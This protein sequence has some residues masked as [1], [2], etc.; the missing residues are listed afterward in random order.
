[1]PE[2]RRP[3]RVGVQLLRLGRALRGR[4]SCVRFRRRRHRTFRLQQVAEVVTGKSSV[5]DSGSCRIID[6]AHWRAALFSALTLTS[7]SILS[8]EEARTRVPGPPPE[9]IPPNQG[10]N[11]QRQAGGTIQPASGPDSQSVLSAKNCGDK[12]GE[13]QNVP[14]ARS[15]TGCHRLYGFCSLA[16]CQSTASARRACSNDGTGKHG[17]AY[18]LPSDA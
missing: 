7:Q 17:L 6:H 18:L 4:G 11:H 1:M 10:A 13:P 5:V 12:N 14:Q 15:R 9:P 3:N 2:P 8:P 16:D